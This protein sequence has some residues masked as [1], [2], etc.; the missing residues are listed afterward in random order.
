MELIVVKDPAHVE[1]FLQLPLYIYKNDPNYIRPLDNDIESVFH[2]E[3]NK[4]YEEENCIRWI[5]RDSTGQTVGRIAAFI[6]RYTA[7]TFDQ[8]TGNVGFF[9]CINNRDAAF[10]LFDAARKWLKSRDMQAMDGPVNLGSRERWWGL[11]V[12]GFHPPSYCCNYN[13]PVY[14]SFFEDYGFR[15]FFKQHT[16]LRNV[17]EKLNKVY[18]A[19]A[20]RIF[21]NPDYEFKTVNVSRLDDFI[22]DFRTVYNT[23]WVNHEGIGEMT[24][25]EADKT[26]RSMKPV[27]D[28]HIAWFA[29]HRGQ[30]VGFFLSVPEL[31]QLFVKYAKGKL[32]LPVKLRLLY[33][34]LTG[35]CKTMY[36]LVFGVIPQHQKK[37]VEVAMI[38][39]AS[40]ALLKSKAYEE[41]QMNWI[42]DFNPR[43][44]HIAEQIGAKV[45]KTHHTYRYLF[46]REAEFKR[47]PLI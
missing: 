34:K 42:G 45:Y 2:K 26:I 15:V 23:A 19:V 31:N 12:E 14:Q 6:N 20:D 35:R 4:F 7:F 18:Y 39:S 37:G 40:N 30:P 17:M 38:V 3:T 25:E 32:T 28:E 47:H 46:D 8:P 27:I 22:E 10:L 44:M 29:Y 1:E 41:V 36:G 5:L 9:E 13:L 24:K 11:L 16:Y 33:N 43:M 21:K